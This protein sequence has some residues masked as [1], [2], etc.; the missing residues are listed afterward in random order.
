MKEKERVAKLTLEELRLE[1]EK[2]AMEAKAKK[3]RK[4]EELAGAQKMVK[5][6]EETEDR[7]KKQNPK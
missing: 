2:K 3:K 5:T 1:K 6:M 4:T 7:R